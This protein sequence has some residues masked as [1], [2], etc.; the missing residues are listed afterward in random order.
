MTTQKTS[1]TPG[2]WHLDEYDDIAT[3]GGLAVAGY[4]R[5]IKGIENP[6]ANARLIAAAPDLLEALQAAENWLGEFGADSPD[7]GLQG[8]V[9][10]ART[11]IAKALGQES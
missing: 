4:Y 6:E 3:Q 1:Y 7:T 10:Q 8:L 11:A 5:G 2:P 9:K